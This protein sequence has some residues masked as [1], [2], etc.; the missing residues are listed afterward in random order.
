M[1]IHK[2][3]TLMFCV[4][5][6]TCL[7]CILRI[8]SAF[9]WS[10]ALCFG[11]LS[12]LKCA[13]VWVSLI[14]VCE[15]TQSQPFLYLRGQHIFIFTDNTSISVPA[16]SFLFIFSCARVQE[17]LMAIPRSVLLSNRSYISS[18]LLTIRQVA[19]QNGCFILPLA[20]YKNHFPHILSNTW[21]HHFIF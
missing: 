15:Y 5:K 1:C 12:L 4:L 16:H 13:R 9:C 17:F 19:C 7:N 21:Y 8:N 11:A 20:K 14:H 18:T 10:H 6:Y 3:Y 2:Q